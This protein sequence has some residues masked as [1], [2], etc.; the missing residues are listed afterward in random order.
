MVPF[1]MR[2]GVLLPISRALLSQIM[3]L[4]V[5]AV[6]IAQQTAIASINI[7]VT[8]TPL[9]TGPQGSASALNVNQVIWGQPFQQDQ[10]IFEL[11]INT[12]SIDIGYVSDA[13]VLFSDAEG[14]LQSVSRRLA[15]SQPG[16]GKGRPTVGN[17][18]VVYT[19]L[20]RR[21]SKETKNGPAL[22]LR[23]D[24]GGLIGS[25]MA[26]L[27]APPKEPEVTTLTTLRWDL[28]KSPKGTLAAWPMGDG[29]GPFEIATKSLLGIASGVQ[30]AYFAVGPLHRMTS[31]D[32]YM[33]T[34]ETNVFNMYWFGTPTFDPL[35]LGTRLQKL[36][37]EMSAFFRDKGNS[38]RIFLRHNPFRGSLTGTALRRSFMYGYDESERDCPPS[39][40]DREAVLAH[41]MVHNW[42]L[43]TRESVADNW[44]HEGLAE[45]YQVLLRF[46]FGLLSAR[47]YLQQVNEKLVAYYTNPLAT[48]SLERVQKVTW[49]M[50]D[51]QRMPYMR[52][53][54]FALQVNDVLRTAGHS[55]D[56]LVG[57][58]ADRLQGGES[59][60]VED[61]LQRLSQLLGGDETRA[62]SLVTEM[63]EVRLVQ[64]KLEKFE[65]GFDE[66]SLLQGPRIV[67]GLIQGSRA[68]LAGIQDG[69]RIELECGST[70]LTV[71]S[72]FSATL[73]L[74]VFREGNAPF[75]V[76]FWPRSQDKVEAYQRQRH[77]R[78]DVSYGL[79]R[80]VGK[81]STHLAHVKVDTCLEGKIVVQLDFL[82][83]DIR[84]VKVLEP[85]GQLNKDKHAA[86]GGL[87]WDAMFVKGLA[88][89]NVACPQTTLVDSEIFVHSLCVRQEMGEKGSREGADPGKQGQTAAC[90]PEQLIACHQETQ[91]DT[92]GCE[93]F[94]GT[95]QAV[96]VLFEDAVVGTI[97]DA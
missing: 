28:S 37:R 4:S 57:P 21:V 74:R 38:Y 48:W 78:F 55:I 95:V 75:V 51:A 76:E 73:K 67:K 96:D 46:R 85:L 71:R 88:R 30:E 3:I 17:I 22:D 15:Q 86:I 11:F 25:G 70:H 89:R 62:D 27:G 83:L 14:E 91:T 35:P 41:E 29:E 94:A 10:D 59:V 90:F 39:L 26:F 1:K 65:L 18:S 31:P 42:V 36:F 32:N 92:S 2:Q 43:L 52:G 8:L 79:K 47:E 16:S 45:Y 81:S 58:L 68:Q 5:T 50:T 34:N 61:Y 13:G 9:F 64:R 56:D 84:S 69:D 40:Q 82:T 54:A 63:K 72:Q 24:Q 20:P 19:A 87:E 66:S 93:V 49:N 97:L 7:G 6:A 12:V 53:F 44:Y 23:V 80:P 60:G 33:H 77:L